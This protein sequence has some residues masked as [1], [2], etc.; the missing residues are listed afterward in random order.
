MKQISNL[1]IVGSSIEGWEGWGVFFLS[2]S[3]T[4]VKKDREFLRVPN[5]SSRKGKRTPSERENCSLDHDTVNTGKTSS[6]REEYTP[7][8]LSFSLRPK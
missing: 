6:Y 2:F 5:V 4:F 7:S 1:D 8:P 3:F